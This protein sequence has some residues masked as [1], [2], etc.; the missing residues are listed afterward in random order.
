MHA[1][2]Y[3]Y[4]KKKTLTLVGDQRQNSL[5]I[6]SFNGFSKTCS[7]INGNPLGINATN[8]GMASLATHV[9]HETR[10]CASIEAVG[11]NASIDIVPS[12][13]SICQGA[14]TTLQ[15]I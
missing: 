4:S 10:E 12:A 9:L 3:I 5:L 14:A 15:A 11:N 8:L 7:F 1:C 6:G 2:E 13:N